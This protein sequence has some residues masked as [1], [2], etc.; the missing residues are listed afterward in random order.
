MILTAKFHSLHAKESESEILE[1]PESGVGVGNFVKAESESGVGN[2][3]KVG[4][5]VGYFTSGS[6]TL[7]SISVA[8]STKKLSTLYDLTSLPFSSLS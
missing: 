2:L 7:V 8:L 4:V 6:A 1:K 5:G 3:G